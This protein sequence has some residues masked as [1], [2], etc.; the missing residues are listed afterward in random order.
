MRTLLLH[1]ILLGENT[2]PCFGGRSGAFSP[3]SL[4][5]K[6]SQQAP[7]D[8]GSGIALVCITWKTGQQMLT[9]YFWVVGLRGLFF[10]TFL[11]ISELFYKGC[12]LI[13]A[14]SSCFWYIPRSLFFSSKYFVLY[15]VTFSLTHTLFRRFFF[16]LVCDVLG[17]RTGL[18]LTSNFLSPL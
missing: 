7:E 11:C 6:I 18:L 13:F 10:F 4:D 9:D 14:T 3:L 1:K 2:Y 5:I 15:I 8:G 17:G 12:A 16:F